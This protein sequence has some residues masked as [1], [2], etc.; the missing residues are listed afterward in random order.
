MCLFLKKYFLLIRAGGVGGGPLSMQRVLRFIGLQ[1]AAI[2]AADPNVL[3]GNAATS[4]RA[5]NDAFPDSCEL[6]EAN[7][8]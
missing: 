5:I 1:N 8:L 3:I 4:E 6:F 2:R 7:E